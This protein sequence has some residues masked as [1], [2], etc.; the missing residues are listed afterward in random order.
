MEIGNQRVASEFV[1]SENPAVLTAGAKTTDEN[2]K[3]N[4]VAVRAMFSNAKPM[5]VRGSFRSLYFVD[6]LSKAVVSFGSWWIP[7]EC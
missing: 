1:P 2:V 7:A 3:M 4:V 6:P 5:K